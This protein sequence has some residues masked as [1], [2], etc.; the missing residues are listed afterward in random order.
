MSAKSEGGGPQVTRFSVIAL[1]ALIFAVITVVMGGIVRITGSGLGC[2]DWPLCHGNLIPPWEMAPWL[3][4]MHRLSASLAGISTIFLLVISIRTF[5]FRHRIT[6]IA[7]IVTVL[8]LIQAALGAYTVLS[9]L[10]PL[11]AIV[12]TA[13]GI[14]YVAI[15]VLIL[16]VTNKSSWKNSENL[17]EKNKKEL[18]TQALILSVVTFFL[19]MSGTYVTRTLG[20]PSACMSFPMCGTPIQEMTSIHWIHMSHRL[21]SLLAILI[22][23]STVIKSL[24]LGIPAVKGIMYLLVT[25]LTIQVILGLGNVILRLP[26]E[27]RAMHVAVGILFFTTTVFLAA[28]LWQEKILGV[29]ST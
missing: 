21:I 27:I 4:Y 19:L 18:K 16:S 14:S 8:L 26:S 11:I 28:K 13:V 20:S 12:H 22:L 17:N 25:L 7:A 23:G 10:S 5:K 2:P 15:L 3:E 1:L 29:K 24:H 9:E 6:K